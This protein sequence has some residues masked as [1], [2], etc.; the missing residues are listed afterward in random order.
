MNNLDLSFILLS[1]SSLFALLNP[2][3][4]TPSINAG[5]NKGIFNYNLNFQYTESNGYDLTPNEGEYNMTLDQNKSNIFNHIL[6]VSPSDKHDYQF[7][8]KDYSSNISRYD[9][10]GG[11]LVLGA[12]FNKY[13]DKYSKIK[14]GYKISSNQNFKISYLKE[15]CLHILKRFQIK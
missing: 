4:I 13:D 15:K 11:S 2:I 1:F 8:Y 3:G 9:Y 12:P 7:V 10:F 6:S 5:F 14:Y